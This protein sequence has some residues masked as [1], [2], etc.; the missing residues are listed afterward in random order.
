MSYRLDEQ[1][2]NVGIHVELYHLS[3]VSSNQWKH[4]AKDFLPT[5]ARF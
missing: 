4:A 3:Q 5:P 2:M 1:G